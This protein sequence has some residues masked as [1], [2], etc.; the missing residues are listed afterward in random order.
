[1]SSYVRWQDIREDLVE[2]AGGEEAVER[3][4]QELLAQVVGHRLGELRKERQLTQQQVADRMGVT[5]GRISQIESGKISGQEVIARYAQA[6][7]GSLQQAI[8][9]EDGK[10]E[11]LA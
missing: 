1:M 2:K 9:F 11:A 5:K 4:K 6:L 3:G 8:L 7:G 10:L